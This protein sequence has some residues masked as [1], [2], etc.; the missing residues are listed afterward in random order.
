MSEYISA[1][2]KNS[3]ERESRLTVSTLSPQT[4]DSSSVSRSNVDS[5]EKN[6]MK[7]CGERLLFEKDIQSQEAFETFA[8]DL[9]MKPL[10]DIN[11]SMVPRTHNNLNEESTP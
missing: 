8:K 4:N 10:M 9:N 11:E 6:N 1:L 3:A 2:R 7:Y 5:E